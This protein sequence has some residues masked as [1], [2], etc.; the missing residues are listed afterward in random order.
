M[1]LVLL[2]PVACSVARLNLARCRSHGSGLGAFDDA[3][4]IITGDYADSRA[5]G[6]NPLV[7]LWVVLVD[8]PAPR[9]PG[10]P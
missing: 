3:S 8:D 2:C 7:C 1:G 5:C 10:M 4:S 9:M 6:R